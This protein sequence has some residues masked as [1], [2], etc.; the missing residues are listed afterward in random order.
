MQR[1]LNVL[2]FGAARPARH[3]ATRGE[4]RSTRSESSLLSPTPQLL[5]AFGVRST[6]GAHVNEFTASS[7]PTFLACAGILADMVGKLPFKLYRKTAAGHQEQ[8]DHPAH[9][10]ISKA[11]GFDRTPFELKR[12][13]QTGVGFG[14]NGY[15]LVGRNAYYEPQELRWLRPC[16]VNPVML[17]DNTV[18]Y[19]VRGFDR[20]LTRAEVL[21]VQSLSSD[22]VMGLSPV[23]ILRESLGLAMTQREQSASIYANG[24][25]F[26]GFLVSP[27]SQTPQQIQDAREQWK[28]QHAGAPNAGTT[29]ILWGGWDYKSIQGMSMEDAEFLDSRKFERSEI[30]IAFRVPGVLIG[31]NEKTSSWGTGVE[32]ISLGFL[33]YCFDPWLVN[34]EQALGFT[35]LTAKE[36][37]SD[38][39]FK[40]NRRALLAAALEAQASFFKIMRDIGVYSPD[41]VRELL[42]ENKLPDGAGGSSYDKPFNGSGG[43]AAAIETPA[44]PMVEPAAAPIGGKKK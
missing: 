14:G 22:G 25:K 44:E 37:Q 6:A 41:D 43:K 5:E 18:G 32:Q 33:N 40:A 34:W 15:A 42:D 35:L 4:K 36:I 27:A 38:Y 26:P 1:A 9:R 13:M 21:H 8:T 23:R 11:P 28:K 19:R 7:V 2:V 30:E 17:T 31:D 39:Y 12:L 29:P 16:D 10:L 24:A 3:E 20:I